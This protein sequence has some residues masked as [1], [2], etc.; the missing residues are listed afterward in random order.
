MAESI[1]RKNIDLDILD[2]YDGKIKG[3]VDDKVGN[4]WSYH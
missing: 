4:G 2:Y 3:Y 1:I